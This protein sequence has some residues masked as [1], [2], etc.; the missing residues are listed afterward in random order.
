MKINLE[1]YKDH[2]PENVGEDIY[3]NHC[4]NPNPHSGD[5]NM[6]FHLTRTDV[7]KVEGFCFHC[8]GGGIYEDKLE[9]ILS[10]VAP[11]KRKKSGNIANLPDVSF[12]DDPEYFTTPSFSAE[13]AAEFKEELPKNIREWWVGHGLKPRDFLFFGVRLVRVGSSL[14]CAIPFSHG[15]E[16]IGY[17]VRLFS[18]KLKEKYQAKWLSVGKHFCSPLLATPY[19]DFSQDKRTLVITED[20]ISAMRCGRHCFSL[21]LLGVHLKDE[22]LCAIFSEQ[23]EKIVVWLDNDN[24]SVC[25]AAKKIRDRLKATFNTVRIDLKKEPKE[26]VHERELREVIF[27]G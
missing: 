10:T 21:P 12:W 3:I 25:R 4:K 2:F 27:R 1:D 22:H 19:L 16:K 20:I 24:E 13:S 14:G 6:G 7:G 23:F 18:D 26:F 8:N 17:Q 5:K 15:S 11:P 9:R